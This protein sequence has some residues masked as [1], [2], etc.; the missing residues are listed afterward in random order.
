MKTHSY[1]S[2]LFKCEECEFFGTNHLT[3]E[4]HLGK[5]HSANFECG[6][7]EVEAKDLENLEMHLFTCEIYEC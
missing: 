6:L 3:M 7:C 4:V 2:A 5:E 1:K